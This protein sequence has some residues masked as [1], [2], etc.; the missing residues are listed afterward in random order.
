[1]AK[2]IT[3]TA[4]RKALTEVFTC[5]V[6]DSKV[7]AINYVVRNR[8][9]VRSLVLWDA[10]YTLGNMWTGMTEREAAQQGVT[11]EDVQQYL[12]QHGATKHARITRNNTRSY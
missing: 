5:R 4:I 1:M 10:G 9:G 8:K 7:P 2:K 12:E 11:L 3:T 6:T